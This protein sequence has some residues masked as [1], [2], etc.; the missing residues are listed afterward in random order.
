MIKIEP[1][2]AEIKC[3]ASEGMLPTEL[4]VTIR[5]VGAI[6]SLFVDRSLVRTE[7][8]V[9]W[10]RVYRGAIA[11]SLSRVLLPS[12]AFGTNSRWLT[13]RTGDMRFL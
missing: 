12:E 2:H 10:L 9:S 5:G 8:G 13:V 4:A 3:E 11:P 6:V 1:L 7:D